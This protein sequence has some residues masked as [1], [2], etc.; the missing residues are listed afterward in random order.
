MPDL[1][2]GTRSG[3]QRRAREAPAGRNSG[4]LHV[5]DARARRREREDK[6]GQ[7]SALRDDAH[8]CD[9]RTCQL[10]DHAPSLRRLHR[11]P[12]TSIDRSPSCS[13]PSSS[14]RCGT[15][16]SSC[17]RRW[18]WCLSAA[19]PLRN[20]PLDAIPGPLRHAGHHLYRMAGPGA[21]DRSGSSHV[22]DHDEDALGAEGEGG[23]RLLIL[24]L[25]VCLCDLRGRHRS[26]LGAKPGARVSQF[27]QRRSCRRMSPRRSARM[28][29]ALAGHSCIRSTRRSA[30][31]PSCVRCR[32][33]I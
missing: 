6:P 31:S 7:M 32:T 1:R 26:V 24:R 28:R 21:A 25:L 11:H 8:P 9:D 17:W 16:S 4:S 13:R 15:N 27:A 22:S 3:A 18:R 23:A 19:F 29:R 14:F 30:A 5:P 20:I 12:S 2:H 10:R 33:G